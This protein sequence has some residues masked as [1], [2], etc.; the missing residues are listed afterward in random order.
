[1]TLVLESNCHQH[2]LKVMKDPLKECDQ[3][4]VQRDSTDQMNFNAST[5]KIWLF[6]GYLLSISIFGLNHQQKT[7]VVY[8][9]QMQLLS[10]LVLDLPKAMFVLRLL[11]K[12]L[13]WERR[14][15]VETAFW[16]MLAKT[17]I[18]LGFKQLNWITRIF[19]FGRF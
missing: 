7:L 1:M 16:E 13:C 2:M 12:S 4:A 10:C 15:S 14:S 3:F 6:S 5:R 19:Y 8:S 9:L 11:L 17:H 18:L